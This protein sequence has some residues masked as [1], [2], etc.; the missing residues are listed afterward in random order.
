[1]HSSSSV[2]TPLVLYLWWNSLCYNIA[3]GFNT[4]IILKTF[5]RWTIM[6]C[7]WND[8]S[9]FTYSIHWCRKCGVREWPQL[10]SSGKGRQMHEEWRTLNFWRKSKQGE[11]QLKR[12]Q[13]HSLHRQREALGYGFVHRVWCIVRTYICMLHFV[14]YIQYGRAYSSVSRVPVVAIGFTSLS[15]CWLCHIWTLLQYSLPSCVRS[16][17]IEEHVARLYHSDG[18]VCTVGGHVFTVV[19]LF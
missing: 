17:V 4:L 15:M 14:E 3:G 2:N 8:N 16:H 13:H 10:L 6:Y 7:H 9:C 12:R 5:I 1:M 11:K 18:Y 19:N